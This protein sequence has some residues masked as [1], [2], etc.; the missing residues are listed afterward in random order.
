MKRHKEE[1]E[2]VPCLTTK[3]KIDSYLIAKCIV[4][5]DNKVVRFYLIYLAL[6]FI[7]AVNV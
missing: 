4:S 2:E 7:M 1:E 5:L 6:R 3:I